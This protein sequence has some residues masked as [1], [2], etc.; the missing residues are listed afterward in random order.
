[1]PKRISYAWE[2]I[3]NNHETFIY[4]SYQVYFFIN[5]LS[6]IKGL[7]SILTEKILDAKYLPN[8]NIIRN[9]QRRERTPWVKHDTG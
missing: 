6:P 9:T 2:I 1:V 5:D 7:E 8:I 4:L 3:L